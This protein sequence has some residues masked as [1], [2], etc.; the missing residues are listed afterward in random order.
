MTSSPVHRCLTAARDA[1]TGD[2]SS[3]VRIVDTLLDLRLLSTEEPGTAALI[4]AYLADI[5]GRSV[6]A[7]DWWRAVLDDVEQR[8]QPLPQQEPIG[9][10]C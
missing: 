4:D 10:S 2:F 3:T 6:V 1:I 8:S 9:S 7:N 5:P